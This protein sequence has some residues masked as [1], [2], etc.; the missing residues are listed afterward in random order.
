MGAH[1]AAG[2]VGDSGAGET[3]SLWLGVMENLAGKRSRMSA[4]GSPL[5]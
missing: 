5:R 3:L 4:G 1:T 2:N